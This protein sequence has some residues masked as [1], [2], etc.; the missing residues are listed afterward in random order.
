MN[1]Q[2]VLAARRFLPSSIIDKMAAYRNRQQLQKWQAIG[3]PLPP[4]HIVKQ[5]TIQ[6]FQLQFGIDTLVETGTY[7]G[8]MIE[9]QRKQ[10]AQI[11]SIEVDAALHQAAQKRFAAHKHIQIIHGDSGIQLKNLVARLT[12]PAIFWL[13]GHY[14]GGPTGKSHIDTPINAELRTVLAA[15]PNHVVIID[16]ARDFNGTNDYPT[17]AE[18]QN[19]VVITYPHLAFENKNDLIRIYPKQ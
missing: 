2:L 16:D 9:A 18:V 6:Q 11:Y 1:H 14:S 13:D 15:N 10:F 7:R 17:L 12:Q 3:C 4:P 8:A 5:Q 19:F